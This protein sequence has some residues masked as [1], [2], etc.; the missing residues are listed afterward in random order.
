MHANV[1]FLPASK[2]SERPRCS[3][4]RS[5]NLFAIITKTVGWTPSDLA[6]R[7]TSLPV[8]SDSLPP[9]AAE[10]YN[11]WRYNTELCT[12]KGGVIALTED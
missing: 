3:R 12:N 9:F 10:S 11:V 6:Q 1:E 7:S 4:A 8:K 2:T 5:T